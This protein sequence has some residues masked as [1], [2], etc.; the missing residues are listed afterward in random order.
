M[1]RDRDRE[2][3]ARSRSVP[4]IVPLKGTT[5]RGQSTRRKLDADHL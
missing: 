3:I 4:A 1:A 5:P 2:V